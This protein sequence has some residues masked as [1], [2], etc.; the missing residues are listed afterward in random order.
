EKPHLCWT[1]LPQGFKNSPTI[2]GTI[3]MKELEQWPDKQDQVTLLQYIDDILLG[4]NT[5]DTF[6]E[7]TVSLLNFVGMA[8]YR[9]SEKKAQ[10]A[11]QTV[12]Y[13]GFEISQGQRK[14]RND[15]KEA[16]C[17]MA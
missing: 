6:K 5:I 14:L 2:F 15:R 8:G 10:N 11:K 13:P 1:V 7:K 3:L 12:M 16:I 4:T 9:V 17:R